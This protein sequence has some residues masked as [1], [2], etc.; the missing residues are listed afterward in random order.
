MN[1]ESIIQ[2]ITI[3]VT[4]FIGIIALFK[5][6]FYQLRKKPKLNL[7]IQLSPPDCHKTFLTHLETGQYVQD[8]YYFRLRIENI[9]NVSAQNVEVFIAS[10]KK[11]CIDGTYEIYSKFCYP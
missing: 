10:L 5:E 9:G 2:V 1:C 11:K 3:V 7:S 4:L 8:A 6:D